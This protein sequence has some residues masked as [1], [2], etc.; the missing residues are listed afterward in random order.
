MSEQAGAAPGQAYLEI[1]GGAGYLRVVLP[2][3]RPVQR[4]DLGARAA[5]AK[6]AAGAS[7]ARRGREDQPWSWKARQSMMLWDRSA[8]LEVLERPF[9]MTLTQPGDWRSWC[10]D[11]ASWDAMIRRFIAAWERRWGPMVGI[12]RKEFTQPPRQAPHIH[13]L[14]DLP[15]AVTN[16]D[17]EGFRRRVLLTRG[18]RW[19]TGSEYEARRRTPAIGADYGGEFAL[20]LRDAWSRAV[21]T[22]GKDR[23]HYA[24][25]VDVRVS[26][27]TDGAKLAASRETVAKYLS[28]EWAKG[29]QSVPP[30]GF[31]FRGHWWGVRG[32]KVLTS[33][34]AQVEVHREVA[35]VMADLVERYDYYCRWKE[36][37]Y[38][39]DKK[40]RYGR[41]ASTI[42]LGP[43]DARRV[44]RW[45]EE[46]VARRRERGL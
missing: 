24:R 5:K 22:Y 39:R 44:Q 40:F 19:R 27:W 21:G 41:G 20:W 34:R 1:G 29:S 28:M 15:T 43:T 46:R 45:A 18:L 12:W 25:G 6:S 36:F 31:G 33:V 3:E 30:Q 2:P 7:A 23:A 11:A 35:K 17:Y 8:N 9:L 38:Q 37:G 26:Y 16:E 10:R 4:T 13:W 14:L 32:K 42:R